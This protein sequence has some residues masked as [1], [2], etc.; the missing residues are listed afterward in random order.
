[1]AI[2]ALD[3][4][5]SGRLAQNTLVATVMSNFGLDEAIESHGGKVLRTQVGDRYVIEEMMQR[6]R[7]TSAASRAA[8]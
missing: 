4:L 6:Q 5:K 8:T 1:M 2:A 7:S 3:F